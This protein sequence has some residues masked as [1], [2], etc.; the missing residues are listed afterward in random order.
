MNKVTIEYIESCIKDCKYHHFEG[1][2]TTVCLLTLD[3]GYTIVGKSACV[4]PS[5]FNVD[6]G[7]K[8]AKDDAINQC[9]AYL[10][11]RL[12]DSRMKK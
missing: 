5:I 7:R 3:N 6:I 1:T 2:T 8:W 9:W 10:G 12:C 4:D 11:F